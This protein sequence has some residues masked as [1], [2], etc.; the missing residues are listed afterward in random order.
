MSLTQRQFTCGSHELVAGASNDL[1]ARLYLGAGSQLYALG[2]DTGELRPMGGE[3]LVGAMI[4]LFDANVCGRVFSR[5][6]PHPEIFLTAAADLGLEPAE[7]FVV[8]DAVSG[9][10]AAGA[11]GMASIGVTRLGDEA[12]LQAAGTTLVVRNLDDLALVDLEPQSGST[13]ERNA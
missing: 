10:H 9:I 7:C 13:R 11:A 1:V 5:A 12:Q 4:E 2:Y 3:H 6:K 8:E